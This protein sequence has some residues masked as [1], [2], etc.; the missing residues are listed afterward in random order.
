LWGGDYNARPL[1]KSRPERPHAAPPDPRLREKPWSAKD[2][3]PFLARLCGSLTRSPFRRLPVALA[4]AALS[5]LVAGQPEQGP[6]EHPRESGVHCSLGIA[7]DGACP[8]TPRGAPALPI[9]GA[10]AT[11]QLGNPDACVR[12]LVVAATARTESRAPASLHGPRGP[13]SFS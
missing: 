6:A 5:W 9:A 8:Q 7:T 10:P 13:P 2:G 1:G 12:V 11:G 4:F 3:P